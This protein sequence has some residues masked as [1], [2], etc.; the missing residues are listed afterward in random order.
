MAKVGK[1]HPGRVADVEPSVSMDS[2]ASID[3][4]ALGAICSHEGLYAL[5][6]GPC[7]HYD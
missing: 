1:S 5:F 6:S 3:K 2:D 7:S 4:E